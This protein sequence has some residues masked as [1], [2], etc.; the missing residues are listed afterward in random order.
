MLLVVQLTHSCR[1]LF[2]TLLFG[3]P[4]STHAQSLEP[5]WANTTYSLISSYRAIT[6]THEAA[7]PPSSGPGSARRKPTAAHNELK[8]VLTRFR[9]VLSSEDTFYRDLISRLVGFYQ[10]QPLAREYLA[11]VSIGCPSVIENGNGGVEHG[12]APP[13]SAD[14]RREKL[15]LV[16]KALI[17]LGDLERYKE[18][19]DE[20]TRRE[21]REGR[22][23][24]PMQLQEKYGK[25]WTYYEVAR[26]LMP[27]DGSAF[28]QL[29]VISTYV[30][31]EFCC[32]YYYFRAMA[33]RMAFKNIG[34]ILDKFLG[35]L[36]ERWAARVV[37]RR[38]GLPGQDGE[39]QEPEESLDVTGEMKR[40]LLVLAAIL[41]R[42]QG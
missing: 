21:A 33:V 1:N 32:V 29:A 12:L 20:R 26:A 10:L 7:L 39:E 8:K 23:A 25:A 5:L 38:Q 4:L 2:L 28:N 30:G 37:R 24:Q 16:Y 18:Q 34:Q 11:A 15:G 9:Q 40:D 14:E 35:K 13:M 42:R 22:P 6:A 3:H 31:D 17:C 19:Y 36:Y 27:D 41:F